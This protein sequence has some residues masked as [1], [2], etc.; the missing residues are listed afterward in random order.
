MQKKILERQ[1]FKQQKQV[2]QDG[3]VLLAS[4]MYRSNQPQATLP[5]GL[6]ISPLMSEKSGCSSGGDNQ[7]PLDLKQL[8]ITEN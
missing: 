1:R 5:Q 7:P 8:M 2:E 4:E 3:Q 6:L